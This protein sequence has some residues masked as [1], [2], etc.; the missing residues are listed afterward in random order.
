MVYEK[1]KKDGTENEVTRVKEAYAFGYALNDITNNLTTK[2][3]F[4]HK[5]AVPL[6]VETLKLEEF[7]FNYAMNEILSKA[8]VEHEFVEWFFSGNWMEIKEDTEE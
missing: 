4:I 8:N 7:A 3:E 1:I 2:E 6:M 5:F